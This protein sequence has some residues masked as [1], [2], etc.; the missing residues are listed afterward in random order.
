MFTIVL[1]T[2]SIPIV[3]T[4][5]DNFKLFTMTEMKAAIKPVQRS[6]LI[7]ILQIFSY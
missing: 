6:S 2:C 3:L 1:F 7:P 4:K 5:M